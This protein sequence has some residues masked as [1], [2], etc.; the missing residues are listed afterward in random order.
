MGAGDLS[1]CVRKKFAT[2]VMFD[3]SRC[4]EC[5][6][7]FVLLAA[8]L[9]D[10]GEHLFM[11]QRSPRCPYCGENMDYGDGAVAQPEEPGTDKAGG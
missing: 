3:T 9:Q 8:F 7:S 4:G 5:G 6:M 11:E 2:A 1:T 10:D